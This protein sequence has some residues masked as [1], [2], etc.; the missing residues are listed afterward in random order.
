MTNDL[1][2]GGPPMKSERLLTV[3][4]AEA[5]TGRKAA[6]WRRDILEKRISYVKLGRSVRIPVEVVDRLIQ[7]GWREAVPM[8]RQKG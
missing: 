1:K 3:Q 8:G 6:T 7:Q 4:Q 2:H 5:L